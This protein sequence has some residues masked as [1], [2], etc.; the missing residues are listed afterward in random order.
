MA[1]RAAPDQV[2]QP[3][4]PRRRRWPLYLVGLVILSFADPDGLRLEIVAA[5]EAGGTARAGGPV[6]PET[7]IRGFHGVTISEEGYENTAR[8]LTEV[9]GF[10]A[11]GS[12]GNRFRY[13]AAGDGFVRGRTRSRGAMPTWGWRGLWPWPSPLPCSPRR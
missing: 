2:R 11:D 12:E 7:A 4:R 8:L 13:R 5:A 1:M 3:R 9:M 10:R 6:P